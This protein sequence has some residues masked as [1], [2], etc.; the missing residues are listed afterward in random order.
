[1]SLNPHWGLSAREA[2]LDAA[3]NLANSGTLVIYTGTQPATCDTALSGNTALATF[4]LANP[5]FAAAT[6]SLGAAATKALNLPAGVAAAATGTAAWFR[7]YKSDGVTGVA[8]GSCGTSAADLIL[9]STAIQAGALVS[10]T[11]GSYTF[12]A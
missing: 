9:D 3:M 11:S 1:M 5:A 8:D 7:I 10:I 4:T 6:G 2:A 12:A